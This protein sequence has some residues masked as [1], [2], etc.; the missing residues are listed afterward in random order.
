MSRM[1]YKDKNVQR[2]WKREWSERNKEDLYWKNSLWRENNK[3]RKNELDRLS[4]DRH[5]DYY[6]WVK[7]FQRKLKRL[8]K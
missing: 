1:P 5:K 3:D 8:W 2:Q 4:W 7:R 6:N